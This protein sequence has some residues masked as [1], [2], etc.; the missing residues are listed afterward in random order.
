VFNN[1]DNYHAQPLKKGCYHLLKMVDK[2]KTKKKQTHTSQNSQTKQGQSKQDSMS[3]FQ[4]YALKE[5]DVYLKVNEG[6][7]RRMNNLLKKDPTRETNSTALSLDRNSPLF[8]DYRNLNHKNSILSALGTSSRASIN[9]MKHSDP[10][11]GIE[12]KSKFNRAKGSIFS[13]NV[14]TKKLPTIQ[15]ATRELNKGSRV[16]NFN[17]LSHISEFEETYGG[18]TSKKKKKHD[19]GMYQ[20][21]NKNMSNEN[22][23]AAS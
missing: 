20:K 23:I 10:S 9:Q 22:I 12:V 18:G 4:Q 1:A 15:G 7:S 21:L 19:F 14:S 8:K 2:N 13:S 17:S 5:L 16:N 11:M 3:R 6:S